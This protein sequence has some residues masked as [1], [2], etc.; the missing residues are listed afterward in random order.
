MAIAGLWG[1]WRDRQG[2]IVLSFSMLTVNADDHPFM[3]HYHK[4]QDEKRMIVILPNGLIRDWLNA[5]ATESMGFMRQYPPDR[6][7]AR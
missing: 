3:N 4:P 1:Q 7:Q 6:L 5:P 2:K